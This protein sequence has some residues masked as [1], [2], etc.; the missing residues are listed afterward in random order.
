MALGALMNSLASVNS[1]LSGI[2]STM[3]TLTDIASTIGGAL[4][5]AVIAAKDVIIEK[6][7]NLK[8][9]LENTWDGL[10]ETFGPIIKS[11]TDAFSGF[12]K[13]LNDSASGAW[14]FLSETW[15]DTIKGLKDV[16]NTWIAPL[17][18]GLVERGGNAIASINT[19][20]KN[21]GITVS[22]IWGNYV[23]PAIDFVQRKIDWVLKKIDDMIKAARR[24][25]NKV[26]GWFGFGGSKKVGSI[27]TTASVT[28][29]ST[30]VEGTTNTFNMSMDI[31]G[32]TDRTDKVALADEISTLVQR[33]L[34]RDM[35]GTVQR[36]R[37]G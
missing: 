9:S 5:D 22:E 12:W 10:Q 31:S 24:A 20:V 2:G 30:L 34:A 15:N 26:K 17:W 21:I 36:G 4:K 27:P 18:D 11:I 29:G 3:S 35:G 6:L 8:K 7:G 32:V 13:Y 14:K 1:S 33:Q 23:T 28:G 25:K 37:Y 19:A 16:W